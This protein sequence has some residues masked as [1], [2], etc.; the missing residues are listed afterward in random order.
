[1]PFSMFGWAQ[2]FPVIFL[3]YRNL[4]YLS[5]LYELATMSAPL[6]ISSY[7]DMSF[8]PLARSFN[9]F[10]APISLWV[11]LKHPSMRPYASV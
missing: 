4:S 5:K 1:M 10:Q 11:R 8:S 3:C 2:N 7:P 9:N 6:K